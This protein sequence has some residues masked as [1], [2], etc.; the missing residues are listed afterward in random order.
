MSYF[1]RD[2]QS[3]TGKSSDQLYAE[4]KSDEERW[5]IFKDVLDRRYQ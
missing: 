4:A 1:E 3:A 5:Q 2:I